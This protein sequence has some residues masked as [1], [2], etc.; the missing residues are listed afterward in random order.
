MTSAPPAPPKPFKEYS[1]LVANLEQRGMVIDD[2]DRAI[3]KISQV[4]YYRLS[5]YWYPCRKIDI[6]SEGYQ[7]KQYGKPKRVSQFLE[8]TTFSA[9]FELYLFDKELRMLLMDAIERIEIYFR[10]VIAHE[11]GRKDPLA[12]TDPQYIDPYHKTDYE[13][14]GKTLNAWDNWLRSQ[15]EKIDR[16]NE[17]YIEWHKASNR[18]IPFWVAVEAWDFRNTSK[19]YEMLYEKYQIPIAKK[20]NL[21]YPKNLRNW[22]KEIN[23]ARNRCAHHTRIW[24]QSSSNPLRYEKDSAFFSDLPS[25]NN[26]RKRLMGLISVIWYLISQIGPNSDWIY[27]IADLVDGAPTLPVCIYTA[28]GIPD[29]GFPR[30][31]FG[32]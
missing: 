2:P 21:R 14:N 7:R 32:I 10:T 22:L 17:D 29:S 6:D 24:N 30:K 12:Y 16:C 26:S 15:Q 31:A 27:R 18:S 25:S 13:S 23:T 20:V 9:C 5:G 1:D 28:M 11:M 19:Y 8:G 4:G 3:R